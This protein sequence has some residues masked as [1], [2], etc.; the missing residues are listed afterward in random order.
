ML[1]ICLKINLIHI[2]SSCITSNTNNLNKH[3]NTYLQEQ[4]TNLDNKN[5]ISNITNDQQSETQII[6][7]NNTNINNKPI[8]RIWYKCYINIKDPLISTCLCKCSI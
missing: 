5:I 6:S 7:N 1:K 8:F 4:E 2:K 3:K